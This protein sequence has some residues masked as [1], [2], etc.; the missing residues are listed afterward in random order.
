MASYC[1][2]S[3]RGVELALEGS[4]AALLPLVSEGVCVMDEVS[5]SAS[6]PVLI[7]F[8]MLN[9]LTAEDFRRGFDIRLLPTTVAVGGALSEGQPHSEL[10]GIV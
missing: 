6:R 4:E 5:V 7:A 1:A 2:G 8:S 9:A 3:K 10:F